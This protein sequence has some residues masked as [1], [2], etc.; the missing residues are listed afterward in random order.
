M[1]PLPLFSPILRLVWPV[2]ARS[3]QITISIFVL[4]TFVFILQPRAAR[5]GLDGF[6]PVSASFVVGLGWREAGLAPLNGRGCM[7]VSDPTQSVE[8]FYREVGC[9][10]HC[11][12]S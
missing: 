5:R 1:P 11:V 9:G 4:N 6:S 2:A 12:Y 3:S 10:S 8:L 7:Y